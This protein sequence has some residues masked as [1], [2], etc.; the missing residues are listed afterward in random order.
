[1]RK[2]R[3]L[4]IIGIWVAI[5][6]FMGFYENWRKVLFMITGL[7]IFYIAYLFYVEA[8]ARLNKD[9]DRIKSFVDN[10]NSGEE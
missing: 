2:E 5:L 7:G 8:K 4:F 6:P 3:A 1:M 9:D 10:I